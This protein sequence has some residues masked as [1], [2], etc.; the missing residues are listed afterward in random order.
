[1][2][3]PN[4]LKASFRDEDESLRRAGIRH[5]LATPVGRFLLNHLVT[6]T[7]V[8][9]QAASLE[10]AHLAYDAAKRDLGLELLAL[11]RHAAPDLLQLAA[12][13]REAQMSERSRLLADTHPKGTTP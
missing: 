13:E 1:M 9:R 5:L 4:K 10:H 2:N 7:G 3:D 6:V 12:A 11:C 8:Y